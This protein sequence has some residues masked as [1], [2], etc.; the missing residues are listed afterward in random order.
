MISTALIAAAALVLAEP[1]GANPV[2]APDGI[3]QVTPERAAALDSALAA[4]V[5][6]HG[7]VTAGIGIIR[8]GELVWTGYYGEQSPGVPASEATL[9]DVAS[10]TKT[11]TA[12][13]VLRLVG[14]GAIDLDESMSVHWLDPDIADDPRARRLT[15]RLALSHRTGFPNWRFF[16]PD[17]TLSFVNPPGQVYGYSGEGIEYVARFA[18]EKLDTPFPALVRRE[19]FGPLGLEDA[20]FAVDPERFADIARAVDADG[21]FHGHYCRPQSGWCRSPGEYSAADDLRISVPDHARF[22]TAVMQGDGYGTRLANERGRVI[23]PFDARPLV[24][25]GNANLA[26]PHAQGYG[27]GWQVLDYGDTRLVSHGGSDWSEVALSYFYE[28]ADDGLI[29]FFNVPGPAGLSAM[30]EA[31]ELIDPGSPMAEHYRLRAAAAAD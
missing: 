30:A 23:S 1:H 17:G 22:L 15:P 6:R 21:V 25:C 14:R 7:I 19:L 24:D 12:E 11:V 4:I 29:V 13:T 10:I 27:L 31:V 5:D 28:P 26:C 3:P 20:V 16:M 18:A 8:D 9:F 2:E